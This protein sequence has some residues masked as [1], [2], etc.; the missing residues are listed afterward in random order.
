MISIR[1]ISFFLALYIFSTCVLAGVEVHEFKDPQLEQSY[2]KLVNE[3]RCL[4]CQ[5]QN[6]ADSNAEL[7]QDLRRKIAGMIN[8]GLTEQQ[9][10]DYMV[11]RYGDFVL[12]RPPLKSS[13]L[14]LW[15]GPFVLFFAGLIILVIFVRH[16]QKQQP[17]SLS[18]TQQQ[19][20]KQLLDME[21]EEHD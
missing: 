21:D 10:I 9:I 12:Y 8:D 2:N 15:F 3:L 1:R 13:T 18:E 19:K 16:Q 6:L 7:A 4:V 11:T 14:L 20:A 17:V 5:N